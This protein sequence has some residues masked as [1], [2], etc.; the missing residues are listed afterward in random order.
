V[1]QIKHEHVVRCHH[2]FIE[3]D[4]NNNNNNLSSSSSYRLSILYEYCE[5]G[6]LMNEIDRARA[7][8]LNFSKNNYNN[9]NISNNNINNNNSNNSNSSNSSE[10]QKSSSKKNGGIL[11]RSLIFKWM[12][13]IS[14]AVAHLHANSIVHRDLKPHNLFLTAARDVKIGD[15][16]FAKTL[17]ESDYANSVLGS[18]SYLAPEI[19][20]QIPYNH[21][22]DCWGIGAIFL[23]LLLPKTCDFAYEYG[24]N[25]TSMLETIEKRYDRDMVRLV[26]QVVVHDLE[27]RLDAAQIAELF[28]RAYMQS[29]RL[30]P[31]SVVLGDNST[32]GSQLTESSLILSS[33]PS[34][35][36]KSSI[37][38]NSPSPIQNSCSPN[39]ITI[40]KEELTRL[41]L[42][43][44]E[45]ERM[46]EERNIELFFSQKRLKELEE[47]ISSPTSAESTKSNSFKLFSL[48]KNSNNS[49]IPAKELTN[50]HKADFFGAFFALTNA[51]WKSKEYNCEMSVILVCSFFSIHSFNRGLS[52]C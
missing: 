31:N 3:N 32:E 48:K 20:S 6:N 42:R 15:F 14:K 49:L 5:R 21:K 29:F 26:E 43:C 40:L 13:Q 38:W 51:T 2:F 4:I 27:K 10:S 34:G 17:L 8:Q 19:R 11:D 50:V 35:E 39:E 24:V 16:G 41:T 46:N 52:E 37:D 1:L 23:D 25:R 28:E 12:L 22:V 9:T 33:S 36:E 30:T 45:L 18:Q 44:L 47:E 7:V